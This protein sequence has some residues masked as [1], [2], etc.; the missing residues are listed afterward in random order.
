MALALYASPSS[1]APEVGT[2]LFYVV[3][4]YMRGAVFDHNGRSQPAVTPVKVGRIKYHEPC[5]AIFD[6]GEDLGWDDRL[7]NG[8]HADNLAV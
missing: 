6:N 8:M 1:D 2:R 3:S 7:Q 4:G 5:S